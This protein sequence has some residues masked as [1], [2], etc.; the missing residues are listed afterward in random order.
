MIINVKLFGSIVL[1]DYFNRRDSFQMS[2]ASPTSKN[3]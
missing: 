2:L 1:N 3:I